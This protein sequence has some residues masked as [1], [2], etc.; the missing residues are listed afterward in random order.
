M[1]Y[2]N[3]FGGN[4]ENKQEGKSKTRSRRLWSNLQESWWK[5]GLICKR[6][7]WIGLTNNKEESVIGK[8]CSICCE[9]NGRERILA[10]LLSFSLG[11]RKPTK[12]SF[13]KNDEVMENMISWIQKWFI[14][15]IFGIPQSIFSK[16]LNMHLLRSININMSSLGL[17]K[18]FSN[19]CWKVW[20]KIK[21]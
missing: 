19:Y 20:I 12:R 4:G 10:W 14:W 15:N 3:Q 7:K 11:I 16:L 13:K 8:T 17:K 9:E 2:R 18:I 21:R 5:I 1:L 6:K